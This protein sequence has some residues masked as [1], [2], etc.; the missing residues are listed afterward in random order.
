MRNTVANM[1]IAGVMGL[2][3]T[4]NLLGRHTT[5]SMNSVAAAAAQHTSKTTVNATGPRSLNDTVKAAAKHKSCNRQMD[6]TSEVSCMW[7][8]PVQ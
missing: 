2:K 7:C 4:A 5:G 1:P 3:G 8:L 6:R